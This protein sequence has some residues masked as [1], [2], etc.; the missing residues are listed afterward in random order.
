LRADELKNILNENAQDFFAYPN[1]RSL[2][3]GPVWKG[4]AM[5]KELGLIVGVSEKLPKA[6]LSRDDII[7]KE[8]KGTGVIVDVYRVGEPQIT[9]L[10]HS[11]ANPPF[12]VPDYDCTYFD[13]MRSGVGLAHYKVTGGTLAHYKNAWKV[14]TSNNHV[15]ANQNDAQP[16]DPIYQP[17]PYCSSPN[18]RQV[19]KLAWFKPI[20][21]LGE[22]STCPIGNTWAEFYNFFARVADRKTRLKALIRLNPF[23][24]ENLNY[25][26]LGFI[27]FLQGIP[28]DEQIERT[29]MTWQG[30]LE[31]GVLGELHFK[32]GART[33]YTEF[34]CLQNYM[35]TQVGYGGGRIAF[36][37][38]QDGYEPEAAQPG[39]SGS[40]PGHKA[41]IKQTGLIFAGSD[42]IGIAGPQIHVNAAYEEWK[43]IS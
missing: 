22:D 16:G 19:A 27:E 33:R 34:N 20:K 39:D 2:G 14:G 12:A 42:A 38:D 3:V 23:A 9:P 5:T 35:L 4:G 7:P 32:S 11:F 17:S 15:V 21:F 29:S 40:G 13:V 10:R 41:S 25:V 1:V 36:F 28:C 18:S 8:L 37:G 24:E 31:R 26:D 6:M 30:E 43:G